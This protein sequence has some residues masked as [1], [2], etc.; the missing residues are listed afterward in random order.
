MYVN[1]SISLDCTGSKKKRKG[2][3]SSNADFLLLSLQGICKLHSNAVKKSTCNYSQISAPSKKFTAI[4]LALRS[5][6]NIYIKINYFVC[7][8]YFGTQ[9]VN[10]SWS[11]EKFRSKFG[12]GTATITTSFNFIRLIHLQ[13]KPQTQ[14][15]YKKENHQKTLQ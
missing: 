6:G 9:K 14:G 10:L 13:N 15:T 8:T 7:L 5:C 4:K 11:N 12:K 1:A 3:K 2:K